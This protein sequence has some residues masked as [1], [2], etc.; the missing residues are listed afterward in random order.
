MR[1]SIEIEDMYEQFSEKIWYVRHLIRAAKIVN[2][3]I[4]LNTIADRQCF[5]N[6]QQTAQE[7]EEQYGKEHLRCTNHEYFIRLGQ[8]S[9]L[10]WVLE[11]DWDESFDT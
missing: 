2:G 6:A 5:E 11:T 9:A 7:L 1:K 3:E 4:E 8:L 10:A